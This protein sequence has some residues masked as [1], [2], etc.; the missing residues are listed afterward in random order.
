MQSIN[1]MSLISVAQPMNGR[2]SDSVPRSH[3]WSIFTP[4]NITILILCLAPIRLET[5]EFRTTK[6]AHLIE[7]SLHVCWPYRDLLTKNAGHDP[8]VVLTKLE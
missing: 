2:V 8:N 7:I 4:P 1:Q 6:D 5:I 3:I